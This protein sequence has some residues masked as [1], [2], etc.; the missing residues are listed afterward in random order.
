[1][2]I[3]NHVPA[4]GFSLDTQSLEAYT[5]HIRLEGSE[6]TLSG[7][8]IHSFDQSDTPGGWHLV[9]L[10]EA[11][12]VGEC[13]SAHVI[14]A[15]RWVAKPL[16]EGTEVPI[17][18]RFVEDLDNVYENGIDPERMP[19]VGRGTGSLLLDEEEGDEPSSGS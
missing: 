11:I 8:I 17:I 10:D 19:L 5:L 4:S 13:T 9:W 18:V 12:T 16:A 7:E 14:A 15:S 3:H 2:P 6:T 1:M